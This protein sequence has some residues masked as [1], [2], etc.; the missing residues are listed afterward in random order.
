[1][2]ILS[3]TPGYYPFLRNGRPGRQSP[4]H[5]EGLVRKGHSVTVSPCTARRQDTR[6]ECVVLDVRYL[7]SLLRYRATTLNAGVLSFCRHDLRSVRRCAY[8]RHLRSTGTDGG[9]F[10]HRLGIPNVL[11]PLGMLRRH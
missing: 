10:A 2:R 1:M 3:V 11:E 5:S 9:A 6:V 7:R 4:S 8:L